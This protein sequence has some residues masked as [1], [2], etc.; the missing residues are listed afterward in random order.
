MISANLTYEDLKIMYLKEGKKHLLEYLSEKISKRNV[1]VT[2]NKKYLD[3][4]INHFV[5]IFNN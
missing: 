5:N 1:R 4:I 3:N 2:K